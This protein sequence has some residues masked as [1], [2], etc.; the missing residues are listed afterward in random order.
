VEL[1]DCLRAI[2]LVAVLAYIAFSIV[3]TEWRTTYV[4]AANLADSASNT[5][6]VDSLLNYETVK[7]FGNEAHEA[8][9][10]ITSSAGG[11]RRGARTA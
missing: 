3:A 8:R 11:K 2:T 1:R 5:L 4:R 9:A 10:T 6:A 7:Y